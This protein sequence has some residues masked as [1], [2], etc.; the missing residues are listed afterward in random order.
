MSF[1]GMV[2]ASLKA[3]FSRPATRLFPRV[4]R[5]AFAGSR[6]MIGID[7]ASCVLCSACSKH[8]PTGAID[9]DRAGGSWLIDRLDCVT[10]G[11]CVSAC[12]K[13]CLS[14]LPDRPS[15]FTAG[16]AGTATE[17]HAREPKAPASPAPRPSPPESGS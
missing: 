6:G 5:P 7:F 17:R 8:C 1:L 3:L 14:M 13:K 10:C 11:A 15:P 16:D 9:V 4:R 2:P 12:P